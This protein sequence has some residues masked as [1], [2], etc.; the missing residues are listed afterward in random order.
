MYEATFPTDWMGH[1]DTETLLR[2]YLN[3][4]ID[5]EPLYERW[6]LADPHFKT[7][8]KDFLGVRMLRQDP[9]ENLLCFICSS[10]NNIARITLMVFLFHSSKSLNTN[11]Q[12]Q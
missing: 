8:S 10:N 4:H 7:I 5:L 9:F 12:G 1:D 11:G 6:S 2:D 3:L